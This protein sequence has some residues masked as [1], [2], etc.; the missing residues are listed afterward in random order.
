MGNSQA[1]TTPTCPG[2]CTA[3]MKAT[4]QS[5]LDA[6]RALLAAGADPNPK[7]RCGW[8]GLHFVTLVVRGAQIDL[9]NYIGWTAL[10]FAAFAGHGEVVWALLAAG[11]DPNHKDHDGRTPLALTLCQLS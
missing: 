6:V 3:L 11:A 5:D 7:T 1:G 4:L 8:T 10:H 9:K 2:D